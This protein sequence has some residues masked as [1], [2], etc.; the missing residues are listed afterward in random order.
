MVDGVCQPCKEYLDRILQEQT[1]WITVQFDS[2]QRAVDKFESSLGLRLASMNE[3]R[4][5][6]DRQASLFVTRE[7]LELTQTRSDTMHTVQDERL[8]RLEAFQ[9]NWQGRMATLVAVMGAIG[10]AAGLG[11]SWLFGTLRSK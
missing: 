3:M 10:T 2:M 11:L 6:L 5:Q 9:N 1:R 7:S 4:A 8:L